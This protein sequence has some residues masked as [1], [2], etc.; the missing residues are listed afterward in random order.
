M[1]WWGWMIVGALLL[2][3][4]LTLVDAQFY[5]VFIGISAMLVGLLTL[6]DPGLSVTWQWLCLGIL[7][8]VTLVFFRRRVYTKLRSSGP[9][10]KSPLIGQLITVPENLNPGERC[11]IE[12]Q[13]TLWTATN[14]GDGLLQSGSS[15]RV[16]A[17]D[18][19]VLKLRAP[20]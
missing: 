11:R 6:G 19:V 3:A 10:L 9:E 20:G 12:L 4:E 8:V 14:D 7:S 17:V 2:I 18:G 15:A 13:G 1:P 16:A 5:L